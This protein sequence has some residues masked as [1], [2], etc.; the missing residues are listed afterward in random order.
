MTIRAGKKR[1]SQPNAATTANTGGSQSIPSESHDTTADSGSLEQR[2]TTVLP[3]NGPVP[4]RVRV[5][6]EIAA[7]IQRI[8]RELIELKRQLRGL[9]WNKIDQP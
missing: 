2:A 1:R 5:G 3:A 9:D 4:N 6:L 8:E 7:T